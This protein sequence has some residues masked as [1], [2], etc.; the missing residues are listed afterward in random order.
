MTV[1]V[2]GDEETAMLTRNQVRMFENLDLKTLHI[3]QVDGKS[4]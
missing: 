1:L 2:G 4:L 3:R